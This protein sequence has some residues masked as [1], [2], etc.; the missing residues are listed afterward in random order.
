M[1]RLPSEQ[2]TRALID[3][4]F[5]AENWS[6]PILDEHYFRALYKDFQSRVLAKFSYRADTR[7]P[8][9]LT[10]FPALLFAV[11]AVTLQ[12]TVPNSAEARALDI[13]TTVQCI[14]LSQWYLDTGQRITRLFEQQKPTTT[15]IEFDLL[16]MSW[17]KNI[18][19]GSEAWQSLGTALR[20]AQEIDLHRIEESPVQMSGSDIERTLTELWKLEHRKRLWMKI[21]IMDSHMSVALGRPRGVNRED[22]STPVPIDCDY[23]REPSRAVPMSTNHHTQPPNTFSPIIFSIA[24]SHKYHDLMSIRASKLDLKDYGRI[25]SLHNEVESLLTELPPALRPYFPDTTWDREKPQLAVARLRLL[26]TANIFLLALHRPYLATHMASR[27]AAMEAALT[28]SKAQQDLFALVPQ[29]HHKLFGYSFYTIDT[30]IFVTAAT[31]K[32]PASDMAMNVRVLQ[33]LQQACARLSCAEDRSSIARTG[34][35]V[36]QRCCDLLEATVPSYP[37]TA[38]SNYATQASQ[39]MN[40]GILS[41]LRGSGFQMPDQAT[42]DLMVL[43]DESSAPTTN[44]S[45]SNMLLSNGMDQDITISPESDDFTGNSSLYTDLAPEDVSTWRC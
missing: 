39:T 13:S 11:L 28:I 43:L 26:T 1:S 4:H 35:V 23:P 2:V 12:F 36:L 8:T 32:H 37:N 15:L 19:L 40:P 30:G 31:L 17:M 33:A 5:S 24:L 45:A 14:R 29:S 25:T 7:L 6:F 18:G 41:F 42:R 44:F 20:Q 16:K 10:S 27:T 22:C 38:N 3:A 21:F 9:T 34:K